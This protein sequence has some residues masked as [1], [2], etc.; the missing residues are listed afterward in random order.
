MNSCMSSSKKTLPLIVG[1]VIGLIVGYL[2]VSLQYSNEKL[3]EA[4][5]EAAESK[6]VVRDAGS[7]EV[8][9]EKYWMDERIEQR[10]E[11]TEKRIK[12]Q[13]AQGDDLKNEF[14]KFAE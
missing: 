2:F 8:K 9:S 1:A 14:D 13:E 12:E 10:A 4:K 6:V 7:E 11:E 3:E 5:R